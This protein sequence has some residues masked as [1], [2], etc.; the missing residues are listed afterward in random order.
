MRP[1]IEVN[2]AAARAVWVRTL[3][4]AEKR[5]HVRE[6]G[7]RV[8]ALP[9]VAERVEAAGYDEVRPADGVDRGGNRVDHP[10]VGSRVHGRQVLAEVRLVP[11]LVDLHRRNALFAVVMQRKRLGELSQRTRL[12][13]VDS[14]AVAGRQ[15]PGG[16]TRDIE[17]RVQP[18]LLRRV[19]RAVEPGPRVAG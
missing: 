8:P 7:D 15:S 14:L 16:S 11:D 1:D 4:K 9:L 12:R 2:L 10:A 18:G 6:R 17:D 19:D 3:R 13:R 5:A